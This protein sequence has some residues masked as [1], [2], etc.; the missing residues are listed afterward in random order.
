[1]L[2]AQSNRLSEQAR[3]I[4]LKIENKI[5]IENKKKKFII[6]QLVKHKFK[7]D[8]VK[9]WKDLQKKKEM[10]MRGEAVLEEELED[11]EEEVG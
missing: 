4:V 11:D 5:E 3:F 9:A 8:P 2:T 1:M 7:P 6:E 10:E